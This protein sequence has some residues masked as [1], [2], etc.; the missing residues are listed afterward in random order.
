MDI[1][2]QQ[3]GRILGDLLKRI[4][5]GMGQ[6]NLIVVHLQAH[7]HNVRHQLTIVN[8]QD[9]RRHTVTFGTFGL[10]ASRDA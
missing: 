6:M 5:A 10:P 8:D 3:V 4:L 1:E 7:F 2:D 9:F